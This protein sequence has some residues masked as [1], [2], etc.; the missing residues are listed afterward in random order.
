MGC[1]DD[2]QCLGQYTTINYI[3]VIII[4]TTN[5]IYQIQE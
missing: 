4:D 1:L 3:I 2:F 5:N